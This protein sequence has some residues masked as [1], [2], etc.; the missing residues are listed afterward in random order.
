MFV[1]VLEGGG[2]IGGEGGMLRWMMGSLCS[3]WGTV[4]LGMKRCSYGREAIK[5]EC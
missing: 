2:R 5:S 1:V 3:V 4:D